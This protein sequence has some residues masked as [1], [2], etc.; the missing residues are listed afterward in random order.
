[1]YLVSFIKASRHNWCLVD[2]GLNTQVRVTRDVYCDHWINILSLCSLLSVSEYEILL[3]ALLA[4]F[5]L[6]KV[7]CI[8]N[9]IYQVFTISNSELHKYVLS[10]NSWTFRARHWDSE[11]GFR[12]S[13]AQKGG[14]DR[15]NR[16][17][18]KNF[19]LFIY[20]IFNSSI[21]F[22]VLKLWVTQ[23]VGWYDLMIY[24]CDDSF[25]FS[26]L[27][28]MEKNQ[29]ILTSTAIGYFD[30]LISIVDGHLKPCPCTING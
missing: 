23:F 28:H 6:I 14:D 4:L 13:E 18:F 26:L 29:F 7:D 11:S 24:F 20:F 2:H 3:Y 15:W 1:M 22:N 8:E 21:V 9:L 5:V 19:P 10:V 12:G 30:M 17:K 16:E 27:N 25:I